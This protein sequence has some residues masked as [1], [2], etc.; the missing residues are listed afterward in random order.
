MIAQRSQVLFHLVE[1]L[2]IDLILF[3]GILNHLMPI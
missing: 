1:A 2:R 3:H